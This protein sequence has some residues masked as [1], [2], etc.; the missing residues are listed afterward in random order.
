[1]QKIC[2]TEMCT[3]CFACQNIC[4]KDAISEIEDAFG[5]TYPQINSDKC[6]SCD[7]CKEIC[8]VNSPVLLNPLKKVY[9]VWSKI[10]TEESASG[11]IADVMAK[12]IIE[13]DGCVFGSVSERGIVFHKKATTLE[14][15]RGFRGS[16]YVKSAVGFCYQEVKQELNK[17]R[18]VLFIG[19]PCQV[20]G[21]KAYLR[22]D[23]DALV[24]VDLIC[25]GTPPMKYLKEHLENEVG[26]NGWDKVSFRGKYD[27]QLTA[28]LRE[29]IVYQEDCKTDTYYDAF[30][31]SI[32]YRE[33]CYNCMYAKTERVGDITIGD[34]WGLDKKSLKEAYDKSI[35]VAFLNTVK[36]EQ[37][38][39]DCN[40][41][42][43]YE[44]RD[45]EEAINPQQENLLHP[46]RKGVGR[47]KFLKHYIKEGYVAAIQK[48][49]L[50]KEIR[51]KKRLK[52]IK[53][54]PFVKR[55]LRIK[56]C[57]IRKIE[58]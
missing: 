9:A 54:Q 57:L 28:Y 4:P 6:I 47:E 36:G 21:L 32:I 41:D 50:G 8:P 16:K 10:F 40:S 30:L 31:K 24:T 53:E 38:F 27:W 15:I 46:S 12:K 48:T 19:T 34:F 51:K 11:G 33:N 3:G 2:K 1:M 20:A 23:F 55:V 5:N 22:K 42:L 56:R 7:L 52:K 49:E 26:I 29:K 37:L 17:G 39:S 43:V 25:H 45:L 58:S 18:K 14:Q 35:S 44:K 13:K